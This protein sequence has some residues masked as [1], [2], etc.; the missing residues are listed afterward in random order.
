MANTY[1]RVAKESDSKFIYDCFIN[2]CASNAFDSTSFDFSSNLDFTS[3][4]ANIVNERHFGNELFIVN[5]NGKDIG[6]FTSHEN[7]ISKCIGGLV[8]CHPKACKMS[9]ITII[10]FLL[11]Y[12]MLAVMDDRVSTISISVWHPYMEQAMLDVLPEMISHKVTPVVTVLSSCFHNIPGLYHRIVDSFEVK[13]L[14][15][16]TNS[17]GLCFEC[18]L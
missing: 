8:F 13:L 11:L 5:K 10:R 3:Q 2:S 1:S 16:D 7:H 12:D 14:A 15:P 18:I 6:F 4:V 17:G 9:I